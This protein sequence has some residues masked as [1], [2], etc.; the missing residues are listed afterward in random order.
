MIRQL[1]EAG[2]WTLPLLALLIIPVGC[3]LTFLFRWARPESRGG[4]QSS[5]E[6][7]VS[8]CQ[9]FWWGRAILYFV[10]WMGLAYFLTYWSRRQEETGDTRFAWWQRKVSAWAW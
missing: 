3:G 10:L 7:A 4:R 8:E 2:H 6:T 9:P 1:L 5:V